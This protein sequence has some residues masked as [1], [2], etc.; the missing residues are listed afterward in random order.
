MVD[1]P[2][3]AEEVTME[4]YLQV[5]RTAKIFDPSRGSI[6][7]WLVTMARSRAIDRLR[8]SK[9][10]F[11]RQRQSLETVREVANPSPSPET[12]VMGRGRAQRVRQALAALAPDQRQLIELAYFSGL[13]HSE[14]AEQLTLP[15]GT[16][17]SRVRIGNDP[18]A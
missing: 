17:K 18:H 8:S 15:L 4:V 13:S 12:A 11:D 7:S 5:R 16:V 14:M 3:A 10:R 2:S 6:Y 9:T 1:G